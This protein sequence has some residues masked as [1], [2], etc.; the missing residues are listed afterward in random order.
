MDEPMSHSLYACMMNNYK[1]SGMGMRKYFT[2]TLTFIFVYFYN[3][4]PNIL[5][6]N[7]EIIIKIFIF[8]NIMEGKCNIK[9]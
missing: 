3:H 1:S 5:L 2:V 7:I 8:Y 4:F 6:V 9:I